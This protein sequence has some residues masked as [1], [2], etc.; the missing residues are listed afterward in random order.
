[1][2]SFNVREMFQIICSLC[3]IIINFLFNIFCYLLIVVLILINNMYYLCIVKYFY[4][5]IINHKFQVAELDLDNPI[6]SQ[7]KLRGCTFRNGERLEPTDRVVGF[8]RP[9]YLVI[10]GI[11]LSNNSTFV[12][13]IKLF[14]EISKIFFLIKFLKWLKNW[15]LKSK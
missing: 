8:S 15:S 11:Q 2:V 6:R 4:L 1:M 9:G 13:F 3:Q 14:V 10:Q 5:I 12:H 7:R